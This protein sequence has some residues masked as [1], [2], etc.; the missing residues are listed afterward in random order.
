MLGTPSA[1][2]VAYAPRGP[3]APAILV[4]GFRVRVLPSQTRPVVLA[5]TFFLLSEL[6][7]HACRIVR[8]RS[9]TESETLLQIN[10]VTVL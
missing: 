7:S 3:F 4:D 6:H 5:E 10:S 1:K 8:L 9:A 2:T